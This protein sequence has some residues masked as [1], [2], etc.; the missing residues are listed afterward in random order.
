VKRKNPGRLD[1][2]G[3]KNE[4]EVEGDSEKRDGKG[5][6]GVDS[7]WDDKDRRKLVEVR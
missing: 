5:K 4:V 6:E 7:V 3:K 1:V 2:E